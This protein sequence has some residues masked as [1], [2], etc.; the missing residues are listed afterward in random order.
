[1][2]CCECGGELMYVESFGDGYYEPIENVFICEDCGL[3]HTIIN[4]AIYY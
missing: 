3:E 2:K 1:M 4:D